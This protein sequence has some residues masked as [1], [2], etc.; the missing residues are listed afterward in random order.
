[1]R[2]RRLWGKEVRVESAGKVFVN[3]AQVVITGIIVANGVMH[4]IDK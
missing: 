1:M 2:V 4:V 3:S